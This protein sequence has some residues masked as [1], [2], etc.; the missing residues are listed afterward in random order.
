MMSQKSMQA[1]FSNICLSVANRTHLF[2]QSRFKQTIQAWGRTDHMA[3]LWPVR[4]PGQSNK[5]P[6]KVAHE[7]KATQAR[8]AALQASNRSLTGARGKR[9][10]PTVIKVKLLIRYDRPRV[11]KTKMKHVFI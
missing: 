1:S 2:C 3:S 10:E 8:A 6:V 7:N 5:P 11:N 9:R 4:V